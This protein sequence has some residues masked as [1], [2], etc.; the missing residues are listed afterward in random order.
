MQTCVNDIF[1]F[2]CIVPSITFSMSHNTAISKSVQTSRLH[3]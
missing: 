1:S 3:W 2:V